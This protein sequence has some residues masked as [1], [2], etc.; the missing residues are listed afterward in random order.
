MQKLG[1]S[2][3]IINEMFQNLGRLGLYNE[4]ANLNAAVSI[5]ERFAIGPSDESV[6]RE[7]T[8]AQN[9]RTLGPTPSIPIALIRSTLEKAT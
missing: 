5:L 8:Q 7:H 6:H 1:V 9:L 2:Y 3:C 4:D